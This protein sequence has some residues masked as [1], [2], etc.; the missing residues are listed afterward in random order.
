[1]GMT[2]AEVYSMTLDEFA[3]VF[4]AWQQERAYDA[5][6]SWEQARFIDLCA[7]MPYSKKG[8]KA[9]DVVVF[10]WEKGEKHEGSTAKTTKE[11]V[12]RILERFGDA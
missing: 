7:L 10:D 6:T 12:A 3:L 5:R 1:M 4:E 8:L 2:L 9:T 11:D